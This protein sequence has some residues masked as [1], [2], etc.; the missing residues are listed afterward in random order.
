MPRSDP[1][2]CPGREG[3]ASQVESS[4]DSHEQHGEESLAF[5]NPK[6]LAFELGKP[7][8]SEPVT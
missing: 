6:S 3:W 5:E 7:F 8:T 2:V 1:W 4:P